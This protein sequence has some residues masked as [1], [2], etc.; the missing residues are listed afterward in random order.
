MTTRAFITG[1]GGL[2]LTADERAFLREAQP[3]GFIIFNRNIRTPDQV[4]RLVAECR[5]AVGRDT[6][7]LIDQ[8]GGRVQRLGP[9]HWR[10]YPSG[11]TYGR[12]YD[13][14]VVA[15]LA[16]AGL[17]ARLISHDLRTLGIDVNC[18]PIAD[19]PGRAAHPVIG[20]RAYGR[21]PDQVAAIGGSVAAGLLAGG[22]LPVLKHLP[23]HG[24]A[25][26]DSHAQMPVVKTPREDLEP[27]DFAA[28]QPLSR[29]PLGMTAHVVFSDIDALAPATTSATMV[30]KVIRGFIGFQGLLM[31]DD[32][33]MGAL[34]GT[35][36]ERTQAAFAAGC[37]MVL[38]CNGSLEEMQSVAALSPALAGAAGDRATFALAMRGEPEEF[39][40]DEGRKTFSAL[41]AGERPVG[42]PRFFPR[43]L[44]LKS[45]SMRFRHVR[46]R[47]NFRRRRGRS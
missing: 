38:H 46:P 37:D 10:N 43:F 44:R 3:W 30:Q 32:I 24:R 17:G 18:L 31:S 34:S 13:R 15:G 26:T 35:I 40:L 20:D 5:E 28:F 39:D 7:V 42:A 29:L 1:V 33:A 16:A 25:N 9:P 14:D 12:I 47:W 8:E 23:G 4:R 22:V 21:T 11:A 27:R 2:T 41:I 36:A 6:P 45:R 19:I